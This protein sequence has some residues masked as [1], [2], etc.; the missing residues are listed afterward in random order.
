LLP[1]FVFCILLWLYNS[2]FFLLYTRP[3]DRNVLN[4]TEK[5][6]NQIATASN[7]HN[8]TSPRIKIG[9]EKLFRA[10]PFLPLG[11]GRAA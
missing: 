11:L 2:I 5:K 1:S 4:G 8:T 9:W 6:K 3:N 10:F 7:Y